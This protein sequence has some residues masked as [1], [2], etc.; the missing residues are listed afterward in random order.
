[1]FMFRVCEPQTQA[2]LSATILRQSLFF[3][4]LPS[5]PDDHWAW[6]STHLNEPMYVCAYGHMTAQEH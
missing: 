4:A 1:M 5:R 6:A 3:F 2:L